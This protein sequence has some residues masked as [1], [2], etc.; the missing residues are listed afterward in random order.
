MIAPIAS[1][2][3]YFAPF[4]IAAK[5]SRIQP[6]SNPACE[7]NSARTKKIPIQTSVSLRRNGTCALESAMASGLPAA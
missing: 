7:R 5:L 2:I 3:V 4:A 6:Q 1:A